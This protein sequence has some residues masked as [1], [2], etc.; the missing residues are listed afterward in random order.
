MPQVSRIFEE[1]EDLK[2]RSERDKNIVESTG[3]RPTL[4][5][6]KDTYGGEWEPKPAEV[7]VRPR[8]AL[9]NINMSQTPQ[10]AWPAD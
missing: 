5:N 10:P 3:F 7:T 9:L 1:P 6:V 4:G 2:S 8:P